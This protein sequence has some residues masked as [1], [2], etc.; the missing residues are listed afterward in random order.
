MSG[1]FSPMMFL[2]GA[3]KKMPALTVCP[4]ELTFLHIG[5]K[6]H[7]EA[8]FFPGKAVITLRPPKAFHRLLPIVPGRGGGFVRLTVHSARVSRRL[9]R[10]RAAC[11]REGPAER[12]D[13]ICP[14]GESMSSAYNKEIFHQYSMS[15]VME[16]AQR[17][18][19]CYDAPC[20]RACPAETDPA[21]FIRSV[22]FRNLKGAAETITE[23]NALGAVCARVPHRALLSEGMHPFGHRQA[24]RYRRHPAFRN[25]FPA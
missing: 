19:L 11:G 3:G 16:E 18:L 12:S 7:P 13:S 15:T 25:G 17:C 5:K 20:S 24:H 8:V 9:P 1:P 4:C 2:A 14:E 6:Q 10:T 23:N 22:R 21:R